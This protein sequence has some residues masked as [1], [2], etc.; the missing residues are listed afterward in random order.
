MISAKNVSSGS[1]MTRPISRG[2]TSTSIG[3]DAHHFERVDFLTRLH[4]AD[5]G[6]KGGTRAA[7][8]HDGGDQHAHF[9]QH[10]HRDQVDR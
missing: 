5:L 7:G 10:R 8:H 1:A 6:G 3:L 4:H 2:T 9:A